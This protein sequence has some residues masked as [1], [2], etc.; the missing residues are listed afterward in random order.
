LGYRNLGLGISSAQAASDTQLKGTSQFQDYSVRLL[1]RHTFNIAYQK[2]K[3]FYVKNSQQPIT[4]AY[5][6]KPDLSVEKISLQWLYNFYH[7]DLSLPAAFSYSGRQTDSA[8]TVLTF[9]Q[10]NKTDID[11]NS[12][13]IVPSSQVFYPEFS[14]YSR[15]NRNS[16][17]LGVGLAWALV[18]NNF[19]FSALATVGGS[20]EEKIYTDLNGNTSSDS[21]GSSAA[22]FFLNA[23]YNGK[24]NQVGLTLV[25]LGYSTKL[26]RESL[27]ESVQ[28]V[29]VFYGY[30]F[31]GVNLGS[32]INAISAWFD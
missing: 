3:G 12:S 5:L 1:G 2:T 11:D 19:Q 22:N 14:K 7:D 18:Y 4:G 8:W 13:L 30:R 28:D 6:Q 20:I 9:A 24:K 16:A 25:T 21:A 17:S 23:G 10:L 32:T 31:D 15:I 29:R 26:G 27:D